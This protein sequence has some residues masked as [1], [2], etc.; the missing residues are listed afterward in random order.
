MPRSKKSYLQ[1][2]IMF[3]LSSAGAG[4]A[5]MYLPI[6]Y[7]AVLGL[8][9]DQIGIFAALSPFISAVASPLWSSLIDK[10]QAY[11]KIIG[12]NY[13]I[14][15]LPQRTC[16][17]SGFMHIGFSSNIPLVLPTKCALLILLAPAIPSVATPSDPESTNTTASPVVLTNDADSPSFTLTLVTFAT[18]GFATFGAPVLGPLLDGGVLR[19]LGESTDLYGQQRLWASVGF[20]SAV[21]V[22]GLLLDWTGNMNVIFYIFGATAIGFIFTVSQTDF[23]VS[24]KP[25]RFGREKEPCEDGDEEEEEDERVYVDDEEERL[26]NRSIFGMI[27]E[28]VKPFVMHGMV[29]ILRDSLKSL[30]VTATDVSR[31]TSLDTRRR[32]SAAHAQE[33]KSDVT[34]TLLS[35]DDLVRIIHHPPS[36]AAVNPSSVSTEDSVVLLASPSNPSG[37]KEK[38]PDFP[39]NAKSTLQELVSD[40]QMLAFLAIMM[41]MGISF[42]VFHNFLMLFLRNDLGA[43]DA[44][45]GWIGPLVLVVEIPSFFYSKEIIARIGIEHMII[46]AQG[47]TI[48]RALIYTVCPSLPGGAVLALFIQLSHGLAFSALWSAAVVHADAIAPKHLRAT[49][50][51]LMNAAFNGVGSGL[52][53]LLGGTIYQRAGSGAMFLMVAVVTTLG[54]IL[55]VE[56]STKYGMVCWVVKRAGVRVGLRARG[57]SR[58][59]Y[60]EVRVSEL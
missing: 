25:H 20:G 59:V 36:R 19:I 30:S 8:R 60:E 39:E 2:K 41:F 35:D 15:T 50:Q 54:L 46:I 45:L 9:P 44:M 11:R 47:V 28:N 24:A 58:G 40:P 42:S 48:M 55:F 53:A 26:R 29:V 21:L 27:W 33:P 43:S 23:D 10:T 16:N 17:G 12:I 4:S 6:Y 34:I 38:D 31:G 52:G 14:A 18:M 13:T 51:G 7:T 3:A 57:T 5:L 32:S 22:T 1:P 56:M 37:E 49:S